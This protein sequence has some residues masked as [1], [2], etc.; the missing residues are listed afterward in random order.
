MKMVKGASGSSGGRSRRCSVDLQIKT[1]AGICRYLE[2]LSIP[3]PSGKAKWSKT[4]VNGILTNEKYKGDA[5]LQ[6]SFTVDFPEKMTKPNEG[7]VPQYYAEGSHLAIIEPDEWEL[8]QAEFNRRK[9]TGNH[10]NES[11]DSISLLVSTG[12]TAAGLIF[13]ALFRANRR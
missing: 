12:V 6:K 10:G 2:G 5:L 3:S 1:K 11:S 7:E 13:A 9:A 8:V 4:T